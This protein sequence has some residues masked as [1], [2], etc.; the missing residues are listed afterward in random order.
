MICSEK[1]YEASLNVKIV[2][3]N[4]DL[5]H[6]YRTLIKKESRREE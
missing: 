3:T 6:V 4:G 5:H 2:V 1:L